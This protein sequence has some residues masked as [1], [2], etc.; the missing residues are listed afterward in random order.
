[1]M[2]NLMAEETVSR[3]STLVVIAICVLFVGY[4][5]YST[6]TLDRVSCEVCVEF[7]GQKACRTA[8]APTR[9]EAIRTATEN[10][11]AQIVSGMTDTMACTETAQKTINCKER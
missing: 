11:C 1:M 4:V 2:K 5:I 6:L 7:R 8:S 10:A 3:K 9:E